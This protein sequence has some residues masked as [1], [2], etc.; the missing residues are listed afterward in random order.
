MEQVRATRKIIAYVVEI[1][2]NKCTGCGECVSACPVEVFE[3][4]DEKS[5]PVNEGACVGCETCI[6][7]CEEE[8]ITVVER[9]G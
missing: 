6:E 1:N 4:Q 2:E 7:V 8:A 9:D 3:I 5:V